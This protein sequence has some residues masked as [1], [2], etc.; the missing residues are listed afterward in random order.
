MSIGRLAAAAAA[1]IVAVAVFL[2][3]ARRDGP[4]AAA[5][6]MAP[7]STVGAP[8]ALPASAEGM[9][10]STSATSDTEQARGCRR[11][12][13]ISGGL[14]ER[15]LLGVAHY[16]WVNL[17]TFSESEV[18][19]I[20]IDGSNQFSVECGPYE[21]LCARVVLED[22]LKGQACGDGHTLAVIV[23]RTR[24]VGLKV[25]DQQGSPL[26]D[27]R[28][29][30]TP[31][32]P[33]QSAGLPFQNQS[34]LEPGTWIV[35]VRDDACYQA[36]ASLDQYAWTGSEQ[37]LTTGTVLDLVGTVTSSVRFCGGQTESMQVTLPVLK[38]ASGAPPW[39]ADGHAQFLGPDR[40][41]YHRTRRR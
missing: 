31:M 41:M 14:W 7:A 12:V 20:E 17:D 3:V 13:V 11:R 10:L 29:L 16:Y 24:P 9:D 22:D 1:A 38:V 15:E 4:V 6:D 36:T 40:Q 30:V 39:T 26:P 5:R 33:A 8:Q 32:E 28:L 21:T 19:G 34:E 27:A 2:A 37:L 18:L 23:G 35:E 25:V